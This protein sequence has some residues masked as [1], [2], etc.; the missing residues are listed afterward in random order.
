MNLPFTLS[1][2]ELLQCRTDAALCQSTLWALFRNVSGTWR[3]SGFWFHFNGEVYRSLLFT[4]IFV[5]ISG[6]EALELLFEAVGN[7]WWSGLN[8]EIFDLGPAV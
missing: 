1:F 5:A 7:M 8:P 3:E 2:R 6:K 4:D